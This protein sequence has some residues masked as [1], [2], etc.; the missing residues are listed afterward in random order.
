M[1]N[2]KAHQ[3]CVSEP[4]N[5][6]SKLYRRNCDVITNFLGLASSLCYVLSDILVIACAMPRV[7]DSQRL[8]R[9]FAPS[10]RAL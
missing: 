9:R 10:S 8:A 2:K 7:T 6:H 1:Q 3:P 5:A 4:L